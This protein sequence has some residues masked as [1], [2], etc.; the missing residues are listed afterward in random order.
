MSFLN[1]T[2]YHESEILCIKDLNTKPDTLYSI[3]EKLGNSLD[4]GNHFLNRS[5]LAQA[6]RSRINIWV[7]LKV[8][9]LLIAK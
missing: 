4:K 9:I 6:I 1:Y 2:F 7:I 3:E 8:K 5:L